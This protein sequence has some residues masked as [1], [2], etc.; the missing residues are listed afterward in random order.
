M[1]FVVAA[2]AAFIKTP[3]NAVGLNG[4][5]LTLECKADSYIQWFR[6][7]AAITYIADDSCI[8]LTDDY[9]IASG[10]TDTDCNIVVE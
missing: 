5:R 10:S 1:C 3:R 8:A 7:A 6:D 4:D 2:D 9:S